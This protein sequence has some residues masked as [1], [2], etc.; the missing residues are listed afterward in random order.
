MSQLAFSFD[1]ILLVPQKS[2]IVSRGDVSL[3]IQVGSC[4]LS[5]PIISS[6]MDTVTGPAMAAAM[7][8][9]GGMGILHRYNT[10][11]EQVTMAMES[12][13]LG[14]EALAAA[15]GVTGDYI[16]RIRS[17]KSSGVLTY[18]LDVAHGH[19]ISM[20]RAL[21]K[22]RDEFGEEVYII[23]GNVATSEAYEDLSNWGA[24]AIR[25]GIGGG[26]ICSTR[27]Q[28]GHGIPTLFSVMLCAQQAK[29]MHSPA[30][31]IADGGIKTSGDAVK[32]LA[33]GANAIM[34]GSLLAGSPEAPGEIIENLSGEKRKIYRGMASKEAQK[35]WRGT[36]RSLEGISSTVPLKPPVEEIVQELCFNIKSGLSYTG[37][38][39]IADFQKRVKYINQTPASQVESSTHILLR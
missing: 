26:S 34:L 32:S 5:A 20:E 6:P 33:F 25:V 14:A 12:F 1:D 10:V 9:S 23:A 39:T 28:T 3:D 11:E 2:E 38:K 16:S 7:S 8:K 18:C 21:K 4:H 36:A 35:Q 22:I 27:V 17:L 13:S 29:M 31:I 19:H 37:S 15:T 30:L 24:N